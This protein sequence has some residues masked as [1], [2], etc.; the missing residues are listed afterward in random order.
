MDHSTAVLARRLPGS[1]RADGFRPLSRLGPGRPVPAEVKP[2]D[3][4]WKERKKG[5]KVV[6]FGP[7]GSAETTIETVS[8]SKWIYQV[9][10][11]DALV[12][13]PFYAVVD[14]L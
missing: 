8:V 10:L 14:K 12:R 1:V 9:K 11:G 6:A 13:V 4:Q 3:V 5:D 7:S 2:L